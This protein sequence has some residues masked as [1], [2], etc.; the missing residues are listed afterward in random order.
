MGSTSH[1]RGAGDRNPQFLR[2]AGGADSDHVEAPPARGLDGVQRLDDDRIADVVGASI[3]EGGPVADDLGKD[4][5][6]GLGGQATKEPLVGRPSQR[7]GRVEPH[8]AAVRQI[9]GVIGQRLETGLGSR[10]DRCEPLALGRPDDRPSVGLGIGLWIGQP[11]ASSDRPGAGC[12]G[13]R[14]PHPY[15]GLMACGTKRPDRGQ[16]AE[17]LVDGD[18]QPRFVSHRPSAR[19]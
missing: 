6:S 4:V 14:S 17:P 1:V 13:V 11:D 5:Q 3:E 9:D 19:R 16:G 2:A 8:S 15:H 12:V 7:A 18:E 10:Q